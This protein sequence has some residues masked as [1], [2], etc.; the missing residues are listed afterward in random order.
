MVWYEFWMNVYSR[1]YRID[2]MEGA[3]SYNS[4]PPLPFHF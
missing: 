2:E 1:R 4:F 3:E